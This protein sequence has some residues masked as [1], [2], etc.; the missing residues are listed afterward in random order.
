MV[1]IRMGMPRVIN[2]GG[3]SGLRDMKSAFG[4]SQLRDMN[5][6]FLSALE[7]RGAASALKSV[8]YARV[9]VTHGIDQFQK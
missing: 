5:C 4:G 9:H 8:L 1:A 7:A 2:G 3:R 6:A